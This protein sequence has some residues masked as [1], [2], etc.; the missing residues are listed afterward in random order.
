[1]R[2]SESKV[3]IIKRSQKFAA[4]APAESTPKPKGNNSDINAASWSSCSHLLPSFLSFRMQ[5]VPCFL[6]VNLCVCDFILECIDDSI[7]FYN[8]ADS[9]GRPHTNTKQM[10][11]QSCAINCVLSYE[12]PPRPL[13]RAW[14]NTAWT[15]TD[16]STHSGYLSCW[17]LEQLRLQ[18]LQRLPCS[19]G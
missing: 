18:R 2:E 1:M 17:H 8:Q 5:R 15:Q 11:K 10:S 19:H 9:R 12:W 16:R 4:I 6:C 14:T 13:H 3:W 7:L